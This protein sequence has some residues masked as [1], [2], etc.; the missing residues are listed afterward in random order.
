[1]LNPSFQ[2]RYV[3]T[4]QAK[5]YFIDTILRGRPSPNIYIRTVIDLK[6]KKSYREVVD[7]QQRLTTIREFS[8]NKFALGSSASEY[9][10]LRYQD[11]SD[12]LKAK[13]LGYQIGVVQLFNADDEEVIDIFRRI[14]SYGLLVN[15]PRT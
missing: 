13:F 11:L 3:W 15:P 12:E 6:T 4:S 8:E 9:E 7:G 10:G 5:S 1:M 2:R 14:N